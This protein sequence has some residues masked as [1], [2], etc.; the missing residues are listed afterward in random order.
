MM[1]TLQF[2]LSGPGWFWR[3]FVFIW[4]LS[5][6]FNGIAN[7]IRA[8]LKRKSSVEELKDAITECETEL[9][10]MLSKKTDLEKDYE[11][12]QN[13][14]CESKGATKDDVRS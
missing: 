9:K 6:F 7:I 8:L 14:D 5:V 11:D 10:N 2:L 13:L 12:I 1:E 3:A 4:I